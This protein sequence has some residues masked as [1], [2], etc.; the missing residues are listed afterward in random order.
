MTQLDKQNV[1][2]T[3]ESYTKSTDYMKENSILIDGV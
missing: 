1:C 3:F 2:K